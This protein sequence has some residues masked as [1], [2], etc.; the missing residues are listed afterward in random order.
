MARQS[1]VT[2]NLPSRTGPNHLG[3]HCDARM[4]SCR[5]CA[6]AVYAQ[7][8]GWPNL[9]R[10]VRM[11][12]IYGTRWFPQT[13]PCASGMLAH[14]NFTS[15]LSVSLDLPLCLFECLTTPS[16]SPSHLP[17]VSPRGSRCEED[18]VPMKALFGGVATF[19]NPPIKSL[20]DPSIPL[21]DPCFDAG[22]SSTFD[23][24]PNSCESAFIGLAPM[25]EPR[26]VH[27][28]RPVG[29]KPGCSSMF[30]PPPNSCES[31]FS[32]LAPT[33]EPRPELRCPD[34]PAGSSH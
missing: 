31:V 2:L 13:P 5:A 4:Q 12:L 16:V 1:S 22:C 7:Q 15:C 19:F 20:V 21:T 34:F 11:Q 32:E 28:P 30:D 8:C 29:F 9:R 23:S 25:N 3:M 26:P 17:R 27:E 14:H 18:I 6:S 10:A 33:N 24:P